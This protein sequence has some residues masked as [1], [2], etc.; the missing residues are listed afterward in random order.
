MAPKVGIKRMRCKSE[1]KEPDKIAL[2][3]VAEHARKRPR[4]PAALRVSQ[5][6]L[7]RPL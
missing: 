7:S 3:I 6:P 1:L 2:K 5:A 4:H